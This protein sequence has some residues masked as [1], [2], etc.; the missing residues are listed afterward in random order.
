MAAQ[1]PIAASSPGPKSEI[2]TISHAA[3]EGLSPYLPPQRKSFLSEG[4]RDAGAVHE[5]TSS[6][7]PL[8]HVTLTYAQSLDAQIALRPGAQTILSGPGSKAMTHYLRTHHDAIL[9]GVGTARADD[10]G[11]TSRYSE[12]GVGPVGLERQPRPFVLDPRGTW[13]PHDSPKMFR[14]AAAGQG[15]APWR[16]VDDQHVD[17]GAANCVS[18]GAYQPGVSDGIDWGAMLANM[19]ATGVRSV[20]IEGGGVVLNDL[21]KL[22]NQKYISSVIVT[23]APTYL[24]VGGVTVS[25][26]RTAPIENEVMLKGITWI[27]FGEDIVMA[28]QITD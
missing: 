9:V 23:I 26:P 21:L 25:P 14:L 7:P 3:R 17:V 13:H 10:P 24:G 28:G 22:R 6:P 4:P 19:A 5:G 15:R 1:I 27:P 18:C 11:P 8:P 2:L 12:D 20:M 16:I